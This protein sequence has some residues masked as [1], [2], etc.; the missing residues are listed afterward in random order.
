MSMASFGA[1]FRRGEAETVDLGPNGY[2]SNSPGEGGEEVLKTPTFGNGGGGGGGAFPTT[3]RKNSF[4]GSS[5][6]PTTPKRQ[7]TFPPPNRAG[8]LQ[9]GNAAPVRAGAVDAGVRM[10]TLQEEEDRSQMNR[11]A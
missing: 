8:A 1:M 2:S 6:F 10:N 7:A 9:F 4:P 5:P 11:L 3:G